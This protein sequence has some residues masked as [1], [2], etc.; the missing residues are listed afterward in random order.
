MAMSNVREVFPNDPYRGSAAKA[1][2]TTTIPFGL[3]AEDAKALD[4]VVAILRAGSRAEVLRRAL[5]LFKIVAIAT[6]KGTEVILRE[7]DGTQSKILI[8]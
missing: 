3:N 5:D 8:V 4:G 7:R 6:S 1:D 2:I